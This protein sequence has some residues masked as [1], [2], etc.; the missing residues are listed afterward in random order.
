[1]IA[2]FENGALLVS[3]LKAALRAAC[4]DSTRA[5]MNCVRI[6]LRA[7][8]ARFVATNGHWLWANEARCQASD[9]AV[10][11]LFLDDVKR[12]VKGL[13]VTKKAATWG[14]ELDT[15]ARTVRQIGTTLEFAACDDRF[16]PY[17][18]IIPEPVQPEPKPRKGKA[19]ELGL[20]CL[21]SEYLIAV[22]SAF[23]EI[24]PDAGLTFQ[25]GPECL[26]PVVVRSEKC[27]DA[28]AV[29]M[30][31]RDRDPGPVLQ[32]RYRAGSS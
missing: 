22:A 31:R 10:V 32:E 17:R 24:C 7:G 15:T 16:P 5:H 26:N 12:I 8:A 29:V 27:P 3:N 30:P 2:T 19:L 25:P 14:V 18:Q 20:M 11:C 21:A 28:L 1:M 9:E 13:D 23:A 4:V 6:E